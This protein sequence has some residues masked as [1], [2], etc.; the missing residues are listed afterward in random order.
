M[1]AKTCRGCSRRLR[2]VHALVADWPGT[3]KHVSRG[4]CA[5]CVGRERRGEPVRWAPQPGAKRTRDV[6][7]LDYRPIEGPTPEQRRLVLRQ[8]NR[9]GGDDA[10]MLVAMFFGPVKS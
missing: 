5:T 6:G 4:R 9:L 10:A 3:V 7:A 8:V 2:P 1:D